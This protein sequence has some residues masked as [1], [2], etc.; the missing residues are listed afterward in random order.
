MEKERCIGIH[1]PWCE[2]LTNN[3][4]VAIQATVPVLAA[5]H[6]QWKTWLVKLHLT[7]IS[8]MMIVREKS[9]AAPSNN[10]TRSRIRQLD[11]GS[12]T[13]SR[14]VW[15]ETLVGLRTRAILVKTTQKRLRISWMN[16]LGPPSI[17]TGLKRRKSLKVTKKRMT[18]RTAL[19]LMNEHWSQLS[20][21]K[22]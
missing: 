16:S 1:R 14:I 10:N 12:M 17:T 18:T 9:P 2:V 21:C 13:N 5:Q 19:K 8:A 20:R 4:L 15:W 7:T 6:H 3:S 22:L 11:I